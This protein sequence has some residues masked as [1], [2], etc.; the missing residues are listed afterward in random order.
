M[1]IE[2][3]VGLRCANPTY[4]LLQRPFSEHDR[5]FEAE[6]SLFVPGAALATAMN[7][8]LAVGAPPLLTGE[9][10]TGKTQAAY[11]AAHKLGTGVFHFQVK[12]ATTARDL[13]N[14]LLHELDKMAF[15]ITETQERIAA[16]RRLRPILY[17]AE[18]PPGAGAVAARALSP[19]P[20]G[21]PAGRHWTGAQ[22]RP[23]A[24]PPAAG[25]GPAAASSTRS[26]TPG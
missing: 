1:T 11:Y 14:D 22:G 13:P 25:L 10:G 7:T 26:A 24:G 3:K 20:A 17:T 16:D 19:R 18:G 6:A 8:A 4:G 21:C 15:T 23:A 5:S 9:P 2:P 12:S